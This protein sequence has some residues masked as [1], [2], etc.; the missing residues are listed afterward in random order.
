MMKKSMVL[1]I[2]LT[3]F[4]A[5]SCGKTEKKEAVTVEELKPKSGGKIIYGKSSPPIT[6]D[7]AS[8]EETESTIIAGNI[9]DG[10]VEQR[11]G[12]IALDPCL[13]K[14]WEIS[15]DGKISTF[16]LRTGLVFHDGTPFNAD[17]VVNMF[18]RQMSKGKAGAT[19]KTW[20]NFDMDNIVKGVRGLNDSTVEVTLL[21][22]DATFLNILSLNFMA[23]ASPAALKQ[24]GDNFYK[25]PVGLGPFKFVSWSTVDSSVILVAN[26]NYWKGRP[27][28]DTIEFKPIKNSKERWQQLKAGQITSMGIP[29]Q[30]DIAEIKNT[31]GIKYSQQPGL[32]VAY[33]AMNMNKK[34][35]DNPKVREAVVCAINREKLVKEVF[36]ELGR[37]AKNPIPPNLLGYNDEIRFTP[38]DPDRSKK[39]LAEA[40]FP[41]GFKCSF[42]VFDITRD[43]MPNGKL[44]G[45]LIQSDLKAVGIETNIVTYPWQEF[46]K[47]RNNGEHEITLAGWV[48]DA[49]DPHFFFYPL[50]DK[51]SAE[52]RPSTNAAFYKSEE[53]HELI[54]KGKE[55]NDAVQR[56]NIY[57]KACEVF[58]KD[59]PWFSI[60]HT[61]TIMPMRDNIMD[62]QLHVSALRRF[63]KV[64]LK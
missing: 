62:F 61:L 18:T 38:Y 26:E 41:N 63:E 46:L 15:T 64:W 54:E 9:F 48:G 8:T 59:F 27:Y 1:G 12:K 10:L 23:I 25:N 21:K 22:S 7:P 29:D 45:Q 32:N 52:K 39:L 55:T 19:Y 17:A 11:A 58:N 56:S 28:I 50:L 3:L 47:R 60:A 53:M 4:L 40:G 44:A 51:T 31:P 33:V 13:A 35:F 36:G 24:Y 43:Y 30:S 14:S 42:W 34:P 16:H 49:P 37:A 2:W 6:L 20:V 57:K 5:L